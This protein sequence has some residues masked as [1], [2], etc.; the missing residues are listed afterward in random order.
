MLP[1]KDDDERYS[2]TGAGPFLI[3]EESMQLPAPLPSGAELTLKLFL[4]C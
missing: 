1:R 3:G 4:P 2:V